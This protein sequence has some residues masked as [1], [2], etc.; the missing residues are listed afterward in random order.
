MMFPIVT[1]GMT[2]FHVNDGFGGPSASHF[3]VT[4][5]PSLTVVFNG[6]S[7]IRGGTKILKRSTFI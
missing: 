5:S 6:A 3:R 4:F 2:K 7:V 1:F